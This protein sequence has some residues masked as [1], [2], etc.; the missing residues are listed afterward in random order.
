MKIYFLFFLFFL[1]Y[2]YGKTSVYGR[3]YFQNFLNLLLL[4]IAVIVAKVK[5]SLSC[6]VLIYEQKYTNK[7]RL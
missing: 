1:C 5:M 7:E 4:L 2:R 3:L 6:V